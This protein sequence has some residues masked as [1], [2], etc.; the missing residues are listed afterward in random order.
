MTV[1]RTIKTRLAIEG[2]AEYQAKMRQCSD[3]IR[4]TSSTLDLVTAKYA[5]NANS[6][7]ALTEKGDVLQRMYDQQAEK[8]KTA[9]DALENARKAQEDYARDIINIKEKLADAE[10]LAAGVLRQNDI[11]FFQQRNIFNFGVTAQT[12]AVTVRMDAAGEGHNVA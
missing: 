3:A 8:V 10:S 5:E 11:V 4:E 7:E 2:E 12:F 1:T 6:I 9:A